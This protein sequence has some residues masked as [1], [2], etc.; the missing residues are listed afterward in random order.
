MSADARTR[1]MAERPPP[2]TA[3]L[4]LLVFCGEITTHP[5]PR[6]GRIVL[7]R[8]ADADVPIEH[9]TVSRKH[10]TLLIGD[11]IQI[12]DEGSSNGTRIGGKRLAPHVTAPFGLATLAELGDTMVVIQVAAEEGVIRGR[13][14]PA[15]HLLRPPPAKAGAWETLV[16]G[17]LPLSD[18][19]GVFE[20][21]RI[22]EALARCD[23][24][25]TRAAAHLGISRRTLVRRLDD[26]ALP[27][28]RK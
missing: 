26:L 5:L 17:S 6:A 12:V 15:A 23:G 16:H 20:R 8:G 3:R 24:N 27:R 13:N 2:P 21:E 22:L 10:A 19:L 7:G 1:E 9:V 4:R 11:A 14:A 18:T 25:Q 28:P